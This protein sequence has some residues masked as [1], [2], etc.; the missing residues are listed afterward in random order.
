[1]CKG[2]AY[3]LRQTMPLHHRTSCRPPVCRK[4]SYRWGGRVDRMPPA[5]AF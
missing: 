5:F 4:T 1:V 3:M 2:T